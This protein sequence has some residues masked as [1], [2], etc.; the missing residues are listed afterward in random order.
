MAG[1]GSRLRPHTLTTPKPLINIAG[2][3]IV[4]RLVEDIAKICSKNIEEIAFIIGDFGKKVENQ[5]IAIAKNHGAKGSIYYQNKALG[6]GHAILCAKKSLTGNIVVAFADTLF[7]ADFSIENNIDGTIWVQEVENP[8]S[9]GVI[10]LNKNGIISDFIEKPKKFVSNLA[11]IGIYYFKNGDKLKKE[12]QFL[13]DH[14]IKEKGEFQLT[15]A[16]ERMKNKGMHFSIGKTNEWLDCGNK[17][18]I[19]ETQKTILKSSPTFS[20]K[21]IEL[22][23]DSKIIA[24]CY[25]GENVTIIDSN[26]GPFVSIGNNSIIQNSCIKNSMLQNNCIINNAKL[27][28]AM[29]GNYVKFDNNGKTLDL[30]DFSSIQ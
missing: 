9:F 27:D 20:Q 19:L 29:I 23:G 2:K 22:K 25:I 1:M 6:T 15:N 28:N 14:N 3:A 11:I 12:L 21:N 4:E 16:L 17:E 13:I 26:I 30:G 10:K 24:P 8:S 7:N 5:L 18:A